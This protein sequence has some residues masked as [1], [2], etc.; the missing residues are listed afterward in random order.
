MATQ[1]IYRVIFH[2]Q[3]KV[4][5]VYA[6]SVADG[7]MLGFVQIEELTFGERSQVVVDPAEEK[8]KDEFSGVKRSYIPM[9]SIIRID[10][11]E[12]EGTAKISDAEGKVTQFPG[13]P[14]YGPGGPK[15]GD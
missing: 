9:H 15:R 7:G 4:Y 13:M 12:K 2:N 8:L 1:R 6:H 11:V 14:Y 10:E 3:G 5:E